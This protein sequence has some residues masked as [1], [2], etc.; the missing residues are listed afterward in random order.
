MR[1][2]SPA[3]ERPPRAERRASHWHVARPPL[4]DPCGWRGKDERLQERSESARRLL[5]LPGGGYTHAHGKSA[6]DSPFNAG[7]AEAGLASLDLK[8]RRGQRQ[9]DRCC[10]SHASEGH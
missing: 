1:T 8:A 7:T 5:P 2:F 10:G 6:C 9:G 3:N 4:R